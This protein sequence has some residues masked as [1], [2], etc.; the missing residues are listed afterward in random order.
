MKK[1][2][3]ILFSMLLLNSSSL[4]A[5][6]KYELN[7]NVGLEQEKKERILTNHIYSVSFLEPHVGDIPHYSKLDIISAFPDKKIEEINFYDGFGDLYQSRK[8]KLGANKEDITIGFS[9]DDLGRRSK[10]YLPFPNENTLNYGI[11]SNYIFTSHLNFL[12]GEEKRNN[13]YLAK[14]PKEWKEEDIKNPYS[15]RLIEKS[16]LNRIEKQAM[17]GKDWGKD[18]GNTVDFE[19][20]TNMTSDLV[21]RYGVYYKD[22][23][24]DEMTI[25]DEGFYG[26]ATLQKT[27]TRDENHSG[28][29]KNHTTETFKNKQEQV[30]LKRTYNKGIPHDTY[31]VYDDF[32]NLSF[33]IPP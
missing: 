21:K 14:F 11:R 15:E 26:I 7:S 32:G 33:V 9:Y 29:S 28:T 27:I 4:L 3:I 18:Q 20:A 17:P 2:N 31:Y 8:I 5:Q 12:E 22:T 24:G 16:P 30:I 23:T 1:Y 13:Y 19:Y 6:L 10:E 25:V